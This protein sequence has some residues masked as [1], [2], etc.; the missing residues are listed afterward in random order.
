MEVTVTRGSIGEY[1]EAV[2]ERYR[3]ARKKEKGVLLGEF[4][5]VT[6]YSRK[7]A[8]RL[9]RRNK[10]PGVEGRG[11]P[12]RYSAQATAMLVVL[13]EAANR[14]C[15]QRLHPFIPE[16]L[17]VLEQHGEVRVEPEIAAQLQEMS[18][19]TIDRRLRP[20]RQRGKRRSLST[21]KPGSL[22]KGSI[23]LR[24]FGEVERKQPGTM[25][26]DLLAHCGESTEGF[27]L[28]T[29]SAVDEATGWGEWVAV[30]GKGQE[31]VGA[32]FH[33]AHKR[34]PFPL[35]G[36]NTD[37]GGEFINQPLYSYCQ[38]EKI[39]FTRCRP[40]KKND[41]A[42]VEEKNGSVVRRLVGYE[43]YSSKQ[44]Y[45]K[46]NE[47]Y[48]LLRLYCNFFQP[49]LKLVAKSRQGSKVHKKYDT[50]QTPYRRVLAAGALA[51]EEQ[52][53]LARIHQHL[54]PIKLRSQIEKALEE[55]WTM[56]DHPGRVTTNVLA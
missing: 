5:K 32:A 48:D 37:N 29:L 27:Y 2:R 36:L 51:Q 28:F 54:N 16:L 6:G 45:E 33:C 19:A 40:Y 23:P 9:L 31:R 24:T 14:I 47:L 43:R 10:A 50:A 26:V 13:W 35:R 8:I 25:Q 56:A 21:T 20:Y 42:L 55:L 44:A 34:L 46:L 52:D 53:R 3:R 15:S 41:N 22:L 39:K 1:A 11:R 49:V 17:R 4:A 30:W 18:P 7:S 12:K 38:R